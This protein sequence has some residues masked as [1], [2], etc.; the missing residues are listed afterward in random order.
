MSTPL[1][2]RFIQQ[3]VAERL[4]A[5]HYRRR[6]AYVS[7]EVYTRLKRADVLLS[8]RR[9][10]SRPYVVVVEAKSRNTIHQ[11]K[12][13]AHPGRARWTGRLISLGLITGLSVLLGY[14]WY[15]R[16]L[17]TLV[18]LVL[19][20]GGSL[21]ATAAVT[22]LRLRFTRAIP[23]I[24]QL[25]RYPANENWIAVG[26][27][28]F[29]READY[30]TLRQQCRKHGVGL[31]VV[32]GRG[33]LSLR[34]LPR[35]RHVFNDYLGSYGKREDILAQIDRRPEYGPTPAERRLNRRRFGAIFLMVAGVSMLVLLVYEDRHGSVIPDPFAGG[36]RSPPGTSIGGATADF[37]APASPEAPAP[38]SSAG[39]PTVGR[40]EVAYIV[41]DALLTPAAARQRLNRLSAAGMRGHE[42]LPAACLRDPLG[43]GRM[44][45]YTG[46]RYDSPE[47]ARQAGETYRKLLERLGIPVLHAE[48]MLLGAPSA[49]G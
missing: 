28:T 39:C 22:A 9:A 45:V 2:E 48:A 46:P 40:N 4:N 25:G 13:K 7:T 16:T 32:D 15:F 35:P 41:V 14:Q 30:L 3:A 5:D 33:R 6:S 12:L 19:F 49:G 31:I 27:D 21:L 23:A 36:F 18:L 8:F 11:L 44:V 24:R 20:L 47:R 17:N 26:D 37:S 34:L 1:T 10:R 38:A 43:N 29:V 42:L